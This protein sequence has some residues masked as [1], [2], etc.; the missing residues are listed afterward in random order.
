MVKQWLRLLAL[1]SNEAGGGLGCFAAAAGAAE[2]VAGTKTEQF[3]GRV[4]PKNKYLRFHWA[5]W[6]KEK[7]RRSLIIEKIRRFYYNLMRFGIDIK[8][9]KNAGE[10]LLVQST[11]IGNIACTTLMN[12]QFAF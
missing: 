4:P 3:S 7:E 9:S 6:P 8:T 1:S 2:F 11:I 5:E 12:I 10:S